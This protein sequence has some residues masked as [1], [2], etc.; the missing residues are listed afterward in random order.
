MLL[1]TAMSEY[2][3]CLDLIGDRCRFP[4]HSL[5]FMKFQVNLCL[6][7]SRPI[8]PKDT[9]STQPIKSRVCRNVPESFLDSTMAREA[10]VKLIGNLELSIQRQDELD[11]WYSDLCMLIQDEAKKGKRSGPSKKWSII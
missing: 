2:A 4:D 8:C 5:L 9:L 11:K 6:D 3:G 10:I 1:S 7:V